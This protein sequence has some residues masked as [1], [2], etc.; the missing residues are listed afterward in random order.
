VVA[1][2]SLTLTI[3]PPGGSA[4]DYTKY[5]AWSGG[6]QQNTI[7]QN[8]GRQGD[9]AQLVLMNEYNGTPDVI[10]PVMSQIKLYDNI[11]GQT[12][13][14]GVVN[15]PVQCVQ[16][17]ALNEWD[18]NC[19]DY[20]F[21]ADN[22]IVRA[23]R[24]GETTDQIIT[25]LT[26]GADCGIS[27]ATVADGGYVAPGPLLPSFVLNYTTLSGA[28]RTLATQAGQVT[29]YGWY[30]DEQ[31]RLHFYDQT[32]ALASGVT[33]T[34]A[35]TAAGSLTEGHILTDS[36]FAY[37]WDGTSIRN[38]VLVQGAT[39]TITA[40][41]YTTSA[42]TD[43]WVGNGYQTAWPLRYTVTGS[44]TLLVNGVSVSLTVVSGSGTASG[45]WVVEQNTVG[46]WFLVASSP[47]A[48]GTLLQIWYDYQ[49][50]VVA[51][52]NDLS[53]QA[54]Y[55][56]PNGGVFAE[57]ISDTS[58]TTMPMALARA[59]QDRTE[60]AFA[61]ER[62]T[63]DTSPDWMGWVRA[64]WTFVMDNAFIPDS[65]RGYALG[66]NDTFLCIANRVTFGDGEDGPYRSCQITAV[67]L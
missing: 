19:T 56:G 1:T 22:S 30:V 15:D 37:E 52:A 59:Q 43:T 7:T 10:I 4:T 58:L 8:F 48:A 49:I 51:Q 33:F 35:P 16:S 21:Y 55:T 67:R 2:P 5:F 17:P 45:A 47:P 63:F 61:A 13:F 34:T 3:T 46:A 36:Q 44:P 32:T 12:L 62:V 18:L 41:S 65:Q 26:S 11:A 27:A 42:P 6:N 57:Y 31:R 29:P 64:G 66:V 50:P 53:S 60:Y 24:N 54:T 38:R 40:G 25:D 28:W 14:A 23:I 39:Q 20:T 9:T